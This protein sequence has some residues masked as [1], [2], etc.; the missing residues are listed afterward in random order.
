MDVNGSKDRKQNYNIV[1]KTQTMAFNHYIFFFL[2]QNNFP[3]NK[4]H[5]INH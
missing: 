3:T 5:Q 1:S 2:P 4:F